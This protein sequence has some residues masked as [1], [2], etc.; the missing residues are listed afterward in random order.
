MNYRGVSTRPI[1]VLSPQIA[2]PLSKAGYSKA[3]LKT[4]FY[5]NSRRPAIDMP[6]AC[7]FV[8]K[9]LLPK[10]YCESTDP[11]RLIPITLSADDFMI[12][13]SGDPV[14]NNAMVCDQN[15]VHGWPV[16]REIKLP[17][18]WSNRLQQEKTVRETRLKDLQQRVLTEPFVGESV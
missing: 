7:D 15:G 14:R 11:N 16:S 1:I 12:V 2:E 17:T 3:D 5:K 13:V 6:E 10:A 9:G 18:D 4:Y 8:K